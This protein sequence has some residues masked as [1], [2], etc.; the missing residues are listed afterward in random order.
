MNSHK[1]LC[2][3]HSAVPSFRPFNTRSS[4]ARSQVV[5]SKRKNAKQRSCTSTTVAATSRALIWLWNVCFSHCSG[6]LRF[7]CPPVLCVS[8]LLHEALQ[9]LQ[10]P[11]I[12]ICS[13][14]TQVHS[15]DLFLLWGNRANPGATV[16]SDTSFVS[17]ITKELIKVASARWSAWF[18]L[19]PSQTAPLVS[20]IV[21]SVS[22]CLLVCKTLARGSRHHR[23]K[24]SCQAIVAQICSMY[25]RNAR[26]TKAAAC[27]ISDA[28]KK[29]SCLP[30]APQECWCV[31]RGVSVEHT[32]HD[33]NFFFQ[34]P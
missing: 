2:H 7:S 8:G 17:Y 25:Q 10:S 12:K 31:N 15:Q 18:H 5:L 20:A 32:E 16:Q 29:W 21:D 24:I 34:N 3:H 26:G 9:T 14:P 6:L 30:P 1:W 23:L 11:L 27:C 33:R 13:Q 22:A 4:S 28:G 19:F